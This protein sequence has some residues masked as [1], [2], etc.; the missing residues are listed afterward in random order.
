MSDS[1]KEET[2]F[3]SVPANKIKCFVTGKYRKD[4]PEENVRQRWARSLVEEYGYDIANMAIE[5]SVQMGTKKKRADIVIFRPEMQ[6][7]QD[8]VFLIVEAK[9]E[10][11]LSNNKE[12]G[13][14]Q[15][16][17]YMSACSSCQFGLWVGSEKIAYEK[18]E[19]GTIEE[20]IDI[21]R[22][23]ETEP[24]PPKFSELVP[25]TD[26]K[27][28]LRRC[29]NFIYTKGIHKEEAFQD[30][31]RLMFC[32]VHDEKESEE[33]LRFFVNAKERKSI[34]GQKK[35]FDERIKPLFEEVKKRYPYIFRDDDSI[36][37]LK[38][39]IV[40]YIVSEWQRYSLM[41]TQTDVK[42]QAYE[43]LVGANLRGDRGEFF[44]P[45][46]VCNMTISMVLSLYSTKKISSLRI[47]DCCCGTGGFLVSAVNHLRQKIS[48]IEQKKG[49]TEEAIKNRVANRIKELA[50]H[51]LFGMDINPTLVQTTQMNLVM[52]GD[53]SV[54]VF[55]GDSLKTPGEWEDDEAR[56]KIKH[57]TFDIVVTNPPFGGNAHIED[58]HTLSRYTLPKLGV[59]GVQKKMSS[60]MP[61][62]QLF[63]EGAL[64]YVKPKGYLAIV[65]PRS[66]LNN[67]SLS[68]I[69]SWLLYNTRIIASVDLPKETFAESGGVPNPSVLIVQKLKSE[70]I[71]LAQ[72]GV[73]D[74]YKI[75][76]AIPKTVGIDKRGN[77]IYRKTPEGLIILDENNRS[78]IDDD[79]PYVLS[80]FENWYKSIK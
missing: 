17:S 31:L 55:Q 26:F 11:V 65:L 48:A 59:K 4:T 43:E 20:N 60:K 47:L 76:M 58:T 45:R 40:A 44:T 3:S 8:G 80:D 57:E 36:K 6:G 28:S 23:G 35:V 27:A 73:L 53:G 61:A 39:D 78:T 49:G 18:L 14:E 37:R 69:R 64:K 5:F 68:F 77:V 12:S 67:P 46:N 24:Q 16:K 25:A 41:E 10:K 42:G 1:N 34:A 71:K 50:E 72:A 74:G 32:K 62:E 13:I 33:N 54:N 2:P 22:F 9:P 19:N 70:E 29:H 15:L 51:N 56:Q 38:P 63:V 7:R 66:I 75:F 30:L 79:L 52:H 21:P